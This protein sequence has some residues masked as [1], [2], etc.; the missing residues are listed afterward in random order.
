MLR[1]VAERVLVVIFGLLIAILLAETAVRLLYIHLPMGL[2]IALRDVKVVPFSD[3]HL[4]PPSLW[5]ADTDYQTIVRPGAVDSLQAGSPS[6]TF[7][8]NSYAWWGG[9]VG[10][11]S[12]QPTDGVVDSV[13]LGDSFTF[14]FT[15]VEACWVTLLRQNTGL[16]LLNMGQ[17]VTGSVSH[18]RLY[19]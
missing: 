12:P 13:A 11:R 6:V 8:V 17:P 4:A 9:R 15:E 2:Q 18:A 19:F 1:K 3:S 16:N 14:C 5:Q 10:F 7:H